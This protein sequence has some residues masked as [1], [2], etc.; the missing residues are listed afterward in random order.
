MCKHRTSRDCPKT[1]SL[2]TNLTL[3]CGLSCCARG[4]GSIASLVSHTKNGRYLRD[5]RR[6]MP[7]SAAG[8]DTCD[9]PASVAATSLALH[10]LS[11]LQ[12]LH[13]GTVAKNFVI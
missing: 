10:R 12:A 8:E 11:L 9:T 1:S 7:S 13:A 2:P 5:V 3:I 4:T 6:G